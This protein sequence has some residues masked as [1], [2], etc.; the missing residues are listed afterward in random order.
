MR[1]IIKITPKGIKI[2]ENTKVQDIS[3]IDNTFSA[4]SMIDIDIRINRINS[5]I[6]SFITSSLLKFQ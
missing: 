6:F 4:H 3:I 5:G 2:G 1:H